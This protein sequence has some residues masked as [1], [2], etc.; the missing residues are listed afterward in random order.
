MKGRKKWWRDTYEYQRILEILDDYWLSERDE[1][2]VQVNMA[3]IK[4]N[5][6]TQVKH[7]YW[8]NKD[9]KLDIYPMECVYKICPKHLTEKSGITMDEYNP[10]EWETWNELEVPRKDDENKD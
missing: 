5:G 8:K 6:E 10:E 9:S 1:A 3:F 2:F 7:I 4:E